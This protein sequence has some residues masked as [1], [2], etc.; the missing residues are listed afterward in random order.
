[1]A[2]QE[3]VVNLRSFVAKG[4][5]S[6]MMMQILDA[7]IIQEEATMMDNKIARQASST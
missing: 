1:V 4:F 2:N 5:E 6:M 7:F 3:E